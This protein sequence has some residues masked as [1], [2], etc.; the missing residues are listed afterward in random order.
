[1]RAT[2]N[3]HRSLFALSV[4]ALAP[5]GWAQDAASGSANDELLRRLDELEKRNAALENQVTELKQADGEQWLT[6]QRAA[7]IRSIVADTLA[8]ADTRWSLQGS[9]AT[10]GWDDGFFLA[11]PDGRFRMNVHGLLQTRFIW[12]WMRTTP[13]SSET[14]NG[15]PVVLPS[16]TAYD[17]TT[18]D[19]NAEGFDIPEAQI[20]LDGHLFGP[21]IRYML[22]GSFESSRA[23]EISTSNVR[24]GDNSSGQFTLLDAWT[25]FDLDSQ[26][27][28][29][30]GQFR[31]PFARE[32]LVDWQYQLATQRSL[33]SY[34]MGVWYSQG[35]ELGYADDFFRAQVAFSGGGQDNIGSQLKLNSGT[36]GLNQPW[37]DG[38]GSWAFTG[39]MEFKPYGSWEQFK[40]FT[41]PGGNPFGMLLGFGINYQ[42]SEADLGTS[43]LPAP[44]GNNT[45]FDLTV[46]ASF[47]FGGLSV[48]AAG[49]YSYNDSK[50][51]YIEGGSN[52]GPVT[53]PDYFDTGV[54]TKWGLVLQSGFYIE[55]KIELYARYEL[56]SFESPDNDFI[57]N[58]LTTQSTPSFGALYGFE[59]NLSIVNVGVNWYID[60]QD[61]KWT[62]QFGYALDSV[63]PSWYNWE[64]G[65]RVT[66]SR[67]ALVFQSQLQLLF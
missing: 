48:F 14:R 20:W 49:Y 53:T 2:M 22:R 34:S 47:D 61:I 17:W 39:R 8:D 36:E 66:G 1:M 15:Q 18:N 32:E 67:D 64:T 12:N 5:T 65:W 33:I 40:Q 63:D 16:N 30:A 59:N 45:R 11:S 55:P 35:L 44:Q 6:E 41:S 57:R 10:A 43:T 23:T 25:R 37:I 31:L 3:L 56:G 38:D 29:R 28:F 51:T 24:V 50:A 42:E 26:W 7:E 52:Q 9:G 46:D 54:W 60:G 27:S 13:P 62:T 21:G 4:L 19:A 58:N